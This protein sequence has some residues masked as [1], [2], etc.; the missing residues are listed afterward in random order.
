MGLERRTL[1]FCGVTPT[2]ATMEPSRRWGTRFWEWTL[3]FGGAP[4]M[5]QK[6]DSFDELRAGYGDT[7]RCNDNRYSVQ[8]LKTREPLVPPKPKELERA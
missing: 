8:R 4:P 3:G 7:R 6:R 2:L 1:G 5:S